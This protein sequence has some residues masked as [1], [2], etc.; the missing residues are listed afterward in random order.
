MK[1]YQALWRYVLYIRYQTI[2]PS[3]PLIPLLSPCIHWHQLLWMKIT[4]AKGTPR[5]SDIRA[6]R[7]IGLRDPDSPTA[8][9][10]TVWEPFETRTT[11]TTWPP[12]TKARSYIISCV[13]GKAGVHFVRGSSYYRKNDEGGRT[14]PPPQPKTLAFSH[15]DEKCRS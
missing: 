11:T 15:N 2:Q 3:R 7:P 5:T 6:A 4:A 1:P 9:H 14:P 10:D 8:N 13:H 12:S